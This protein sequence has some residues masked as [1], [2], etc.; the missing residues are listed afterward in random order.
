MHFTARTSS[1]LTELRDALYPLPNWTADGH[2]WLRFHGYDVPCL[3]PV[4]LQRELARLRLR[5]V[6]EGDVPDPWLIARIV[7][8]GITRRSNP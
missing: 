1:L 5:L 7:P 2:E 8:P 6:I 4:T 3:A